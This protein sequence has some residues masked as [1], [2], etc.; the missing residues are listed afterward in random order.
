MT[1]SLENLVA[2]CLRHAAW[3]V[4]A[5]VALA[6]WGGWYAT[7]RFA[8][9]TDTAH[10]IAPDIGWRQD[11]IAYARAFPHLQALIVAVVDGPGPEATD[12]A[13]AA[14]T[15]ALS[16]KPAIKSV[17][18]PDANDYL[19]REGLLLLG[20][21]QLQQTLAQLTGAKDMFAALAADPSL[22]GLLRAIGG[23]M[24]GAEKDRKAF[25]P[26]IGPIGKLADTVEAS[27]AGRPARLSWTNLFDKGP[28]PA[29]DLRRIVLIDPALD[30]SALSPGE[31]ATQTVRAAAFAAGITPA[32][33][34]RLRLT[35]QTPLADEE[36][37]TVAENFELNVAGTLLAVAF[38]LFL[39]LRSP[40]IIVAVLATLLAGL[41]A[42]AGLGLALIGSFNLI[43][44]AFMALFVGL[45][46][47]FAIQFA[48]RYRE[49]RHRDDDVT[50]ALQ[51]AAHNIGYPL[52]LAALS[53]VAGFFCFL[54]TEF[55][56]VSELGL[57]AGLGMIVA[58]FMTLTF[59][60]ALLK[61]MAPGAERAPVETAS[62]ASV[63]RWIE[64]H[65]ALVIGAT[66][67]LVLA[68]APALMKMRFDSN[69]MHLRSDKVE[70]VSTFY[71]LARDPE[72]A[73]DTISALAP[74]L[75][76]ADALA[77]RLAALP[78]V[79]RATTLSTFTPQDQ[80]AKLAMIAQARKAL[81]PAFAA[82]AHPAPAPSD[83]DNLAEID[84]VSDMLDLAVEQ[85]APPELERFKTALEA[86]AKTTPEKRAAAQDA[87]FH[88]FPALL[89][90]LDL[91]LSARK[92]S[93]ADIPAAMKRDW[94]AS[95]GRARIDVAPKGDVDSA[96]GRKRFAEAILAIAPHATGGPIT[97]N[98]AG[99]TIV[100]SFIVAGLLAFV[101]IF[102]ILY[103]AMRSVKDVAL[104]L[105]P[106][107][108]AGALSLEAA[109]LAGMSLDYANII[110][111]PLMFAV[112]VAFH[113]Y[114]LIAWRRGVADVLASSLTRA[115]FF[116]SLTTGTAFG[117]LWLSSHPGTAGMGKLLAISL[118]FT[119]LAAFIVVPAFLG[120]PPDL[121]AKKAV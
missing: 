56:G 28:P 121:D 54:P 114:Y 15:R 45:G 37:S 112:G 111:L 2:F 58:F 109:Q 113:I 43:S 96:A 13:A 88:D 77:H 99:A 102:A 51:G 69:P 90:R 30:F 11:E 24:E 1:R 44:V 17:W 116:S 27:L 38:I 36:F 5:G 72:T 76:E 31:A 25:E 59:L 74:S 21:E 14:L 93:G 6:A 83:K 66:A 117:S 18:R 64:N 32:N 50:R 81:A 42:T 85:G 10:L 19:A 60:P 97:M 7:T 47:D 71:D 16:G 104:A 80:D 89:E 110:A 4:L 41:A 107:L 3:V 79:A 12:G 84:R 108:L 70:S 91:A 48:T 61:L 35:G 101:S 39:A 23:A 105:G 53:L 57:I 95:D 52:T 65:R 78:Q 49:E 120:P 20:K 92:V 100:R 55:R 118:V 26:M 86:L 33:G 103:I 29:A 115:I 8:I 94:I 98:E 68:G 63:D 73:P 22:R 75:E 119:L 9:D 62:L 34:F 46:V 106:L 82:R 67:A 87:L 40:K